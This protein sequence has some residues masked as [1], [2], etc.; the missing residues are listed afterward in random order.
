M[1][2]RFGCASFT[3]VGLALAGICGGGMTAAAQAEGCANEEVRQLSGYSSALPDCRAYEQVTPVNKDGGDPAGYVN[4]MQASLSGERI[5]FVTPANF[6][7][8]ASSSE[9]PRFVLSAREANGWSTH[10]LAPAME[11]HGHSHVEGWSEDLAKVLVHA[12]GVSPGAGSFLYMRDDAGGLF[13]PI[14]PTG[15]F[16]QFF[17]A[18]FSSDDSRLFFETPEQLLP[19]AAAGTD[20]LYEWDGQT[21]SLV[22]VLPDG[23]VPPGG[24]FAGPYNWVSGTTGSGGA[25]AGFYTQRAVSSD[26]SRVFFTAGET[27][28]LYVR[29]NGASTVQVSASQRTAPDPNGSKPAAF[30]AATPDG[31]RVFFTSCEKLTNDSTAASTAAASCVEAGSEGQDLY[32][33]D[34]SSGT[35]ADLTVD[36]NAGDALGAAVQGVLGEGGGPEGGYLYF[37]ASGVLAAGATPGSC[38]NLYMRHDGVIGLIARLGGGEGEEANNWTPTPHREP[39]AAE[40][41]SRVTP[42][43]RV[44]LFRSAQRLTSYDN[45]GHFELY[46]YDAVRD[47][48]R[49]VSC[50]PSG[51]A[52][53]SGVTLSSLTIADSQTE[54]AILTRNL[55][56]DGARVFFET[57]EA[58]LPQDTNGVKDVYEWER[59]GVGSCRSSSAGFSEASG[60]CLYLISTG[61]S[62]DA[63][64]FADAGTSGDDVLVF[65]GQ[66]LVGQDQDGQIDIYDARVDGGIAAQSASFPPPC[67]GEACRGPAAS[68]PLFGAPASAA[69]SGAGNLAL[70]VP[71]SAKPKAKSKP[72]HKP[73]KRKRRRRKKARKAA[74]NAR[75]TTRG[76]K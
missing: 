74:G 6:P 71:S 35:L 23:S 62:P 68:Q 32:E 26:G 38:C 2:A 15:I 20:N 24:S 40:N 63:S 31:S 9:Q 18:G 29:E 58:L 11:P 16:T 42:D 10:G 13:Q 5:V 33:Y 72:G 64:F 54:P 36:H 19:T 4:G 75:T 50:N 46:R 67:S 55:S 52:S 12:S 41:T 21:L 7:G 49:C 34:V 8:E 44:L 76:R 37:V 25:A 53:A 61:S 43:G 28:Q 73:K 39:S 47:Q 1:R 56:A 14:V 59:E 65:T 51:L 3:V 60:G 48:L 66:P 27:G 30:M 22:G 45:A 17:M 70:P 69:L 57:A